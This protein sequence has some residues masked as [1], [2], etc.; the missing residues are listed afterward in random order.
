MVIILL[1]FA[2]ITGYFIARGHP[3]S[4]AGDCDYI[5]VLGCRVAGDKPGPILKYRIAKAGE[6]LKSHPQT[7]AVLSGGKGDGENI[8]EAA[9]MCRELVALGISQDRL[10]LEE[11]STSTRENLLFSV[12]IFR[13]KLGKLPSCMGIL[14][15]E[16]HLF[17]SGRY[18]RRLGL[19]SLGIPAKTEN[20]LYRV[21]Y[22]L[23]EI[24][25][26][27]IQILFGG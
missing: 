11:Q 2:I 9:C 26:I 12:E 18:A 16:T 6:Y 4:A 23:R 13:E 22:F 15:S 27:W 7:V 1:I 21:Y 3:K 19:Q 17:R 20:I 8:S 25:C 14:S 5:M 24:P 10:W